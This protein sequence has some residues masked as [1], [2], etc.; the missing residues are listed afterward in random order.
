MKEFLNSEIWKFGD[1]AIVTVYSILYI[2]LS[3]VV[4][5]FTYKW[6]SKLSRRAVKTGRLDTGRQFAIIRITKYILI[7]V[8]V[9]IALVSLS[10]KAEVFVFLAPLLIGIGLGL[11]QIANDIISGLILLVEPSIRVNDVVEVDNIVA[12]VSEIGLRT[13]KVETRDGIAMII[14]NHKLVSENLINW[15]SNDTATRFSIKVGVAYGSDVKL[16]EKLLSETAWKHSKVITNPSPIILF[17]DFGESSLDFELI[18]WSNQLFI[19]E[20]IKS[21][22]RFMIDDAFR[23]NNIQIP[24]PQRDIHVKSGNSLA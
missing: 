17:K 5:W 11:Q 18:F 1:N 20:Q 6:V 12:R 10:V 7:V 15:S 9:T 14:P 22:I 8:F 16:V 24:F 13:S 19:I 4:I 2:L 21:E 3:G 23:E